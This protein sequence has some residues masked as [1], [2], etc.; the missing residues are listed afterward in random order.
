MTPGTVEPTGTQAQRGATTPG[1][2]PVRAASPRR[3]ESRGR[4]RVRLLLG[5]V[6]LLVVIGG[7][8]WAVA[9]WATPTPKPTPVASPQA[10]TAHGVVQPV[11]RA[12]I[13]TLGGGVV[14]QLLVQVGQTVDAQQ[15]V[16]Q[17]T[18]SGGAEMLVAPWRGTVTG[19]D[20]HLGDTI[21]PGTVV[22]TIG[23]LSRYQVETTDVDEYLIGH[24][25]PNQAVTMTVEALDGLE[26]RGFVQSVSLQQ[27]TTAGVG[28]YPV[29]IDL[30]GPLPD[31][32][33]GMTVRITFVDQPR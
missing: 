10:L 15:V 18:A 32:R 7:V 30:R 29:V 6:A 23:D 26:L 21:L 27:Q 17:V 33:P 20:V 2:G 13:A 24:I 8:S 5:L 22:A 14:S 28:N 11:A 16:A 9:A 1:N 3:T 19:I 31:L 4:R 12:S 25:R